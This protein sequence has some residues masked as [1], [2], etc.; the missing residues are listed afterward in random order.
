[1]LEGSGLTPPPS[2]SRTLA[3]EFDDLPE[4]RAVAAQRLAR[5]ID[6]LEALQMMLDTFGING[7]ETVDGE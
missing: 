5:A 6:A 4:P 3:P 1:L 7:G 2:P